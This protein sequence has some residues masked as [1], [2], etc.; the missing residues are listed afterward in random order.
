MGAELLSG[1]RLLPGSA[2]WPR[3]V[4]MRR[5]EERRPRGPRTRRGGRS[6]G[7]APRP[8]GLR[9]R[10]DRTGARPGT[11][12]VRPRRRLEH[13]AGRIAGRSG[14]AAPR[15]RE[16]GAR[17][18]GPQLVPALSSHPEQ[19]RRRGW[20]ALKMLR[21]V[22]HGEEPGVH[23]RRVARRVDTPDEAIGT[24]TDLARQQP[25]T[26]QEALPRALHRPGRSVRE[27]KMLGYGPTGVAPT[28]RQA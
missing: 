21:Q 15:A 2:D 28:R 11:W 23:L 25:I 24:R 18:A 3:P 6:C 17:A 8:P 13:C 22:H 16:P 1:C 19:R 14:G 4:E 27:T 9:A 5:A 26:V 12:G 10:D 20:A 7:V